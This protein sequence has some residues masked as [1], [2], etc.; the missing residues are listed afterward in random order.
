MQIIF[1]TKYDP[2]LEGKISVSII[3]S[4]VEIIGA[5]EKE[6][7]VAESGKT[8][9]DKAAKVGEHR[10]PKEGHRPSPAH[11]TT[12]EGADGKKSGLFSRFFG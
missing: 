5:T 10:S 4:G 8:Q 6:R 11:A 7:A 1:G 9:I 2:I 12:V 3:A